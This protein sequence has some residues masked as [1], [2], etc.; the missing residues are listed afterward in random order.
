MCCAFVQGK[1]YCGCNDNN[2]QEIDL[3]SGTVSTIQPRARKLLGKANP[4][5]SM[6][7]Q[8]GLLYSAGPSIDGAPVKIW[9]TANYNMVG[10][11]QTTLDVRAMAVSSELIYLGCKVGQS[12]L[13]L[14]KR[15]CIDQIKSKGLFKG[16][17]ARTLTQI[18]ETIESIFEKRVR[19]YY[20]LISLHQI[21]C[22][23]RSCEDDDVPGNIVVDV[24]DYAG[25]DLSS[26]DKDRRPNH[27]SATK[28][29]QVTVDENKKI[30]TPP[31]DPPY[32]DQ[33]RKRRKSQVVTPPKD[34]EKKEV[35]P[36]F[37]D[38]QTEGSG[39]K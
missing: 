15:N 28:I 13:H 17:E 30:A 14:C 23:R 32:E 21:A 33:W 5:Y 27:S 16:M 26:L 36:L 2:I 7:C 20:V 24:S 34:Q 9:S 31:I 25:E 4:I 37:D 39:Y 11:L 12:P 29:D 35:N 10:S 18:Q 3:V 8:S 6:Q 22:Q 38:Q 19:V 1:L